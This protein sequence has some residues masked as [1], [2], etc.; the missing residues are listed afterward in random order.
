MF[1][2]RDIS[3]TDYLIIRISCTQTAAQAGRVRPVPNM[4]AGTGRTNLL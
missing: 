2:D 4:N 3:I 1:R